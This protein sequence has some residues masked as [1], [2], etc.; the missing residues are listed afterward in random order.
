MFYHRDWKI[1]E[2]RT[3]GSNIYYAGGFGILKNLF[4][5]LTDAGSLETASCI[6]DI[7]FYLIGNIFILFLVSGVFQI[8][9]IKKG[10]FVILGTV[11]VFIAGS[12]IWLGRVNIINATDWIVNILMTYKPL[13]D[14]IIPSKIVGLDIIDIRTYILFR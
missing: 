10:V 3:G 6:P 4:S 7:A 2:F 13:V 8:L 11:M 14:G 1:F 5:M 12:L 9:R